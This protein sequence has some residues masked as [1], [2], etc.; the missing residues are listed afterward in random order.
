[1]YALFF[2]LINSLHQLRRH[3]TTKASVPYSI[4]APYYM[5]VT[6]EENVSKLI[7]STYEEEENN[8]RNQSEWPICHVK[9]SIDNGLVN[10]IGRSSKSNFILNLANLNG[11]YEL[12]V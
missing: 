6:T 1:M 4:H 8:G 12:Q 3:R 7:I 5:I 11:Y 2:K 9:S 10:S